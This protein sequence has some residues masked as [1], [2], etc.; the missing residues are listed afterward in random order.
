MYIPDTH[1]EFPE[2]SDNQARPSDNMISNSENSLTRGLIREWNLNPHVTNQLVRYKE[3]SGIY[4]ELPVKY[5]GVQ[6]RDHPTFIN[7]T[8]NIELCKPHNFAT[9]ERN[10]FSFSCQ[11]LTTNF[12][13]DQTIIGG[14]GV[15]FN[16]RIMNLPDKYLRLSSE[17]GAA[18]LNSTV[19]LELNTIYSLVVIVD[20]N[21]TVD[22]VNG[23]FMYINGAFDA[24]S[25]DTTGYSWFEDPLLLGKR[26]DTSR[27]MKGWIDYPRFWNRALTPSEIVELHKNPKS[28]YK[29]A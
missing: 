25:T 19:T 21:L 28:L 11:F 9:S 4:A 10:L 7:N 17:G 26:N 29:T 23:K 15:H 3:A 27:T 8:D 5:N 1:M 13:S 6:F 12:A 2:L 22:G 14:S 20:N 24:Q 18:D 16:I